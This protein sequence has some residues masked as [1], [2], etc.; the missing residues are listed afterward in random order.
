VSENLDELVGKNWDYV[1]AGGGSAGCVLA[2]RLSEDPTV[3]VLLLEAG[4]P[5]RSPFIRLPAGLLK[6]DKKYNW[7]YTAEPDPS[8]NGAVDEWG[9]GRVLGGSSSINGQMW[10]RGCQADFDGWDKLGAAGW[11][12]E[13]VLPYFRKAEAFAG[14]A[15]QWRGGK[16]PQTVSFGG[17]DHPLTDAFVT[18]A[19]QFGL[20]FNADYNGEHQNGVSYVQLSQRRGF[21]WSTA[22]GYLAPARRRKNLH[23]LTRT[24]VHRV[25]VDGDRVVAVEFLHGGMSRRVQVARE[26]ILSTGALAT[27]KVLLLSGIG[28]EDEITRHGIPMVA[29]LPGVGANLQEHPYTTMIYESRVPTLNSD[30]GV[31][32]GARAAWDFVTKGRGALTAAA[33]SAIAFGRF[34]GDQ[35]AIADFE[36]LFSAAGVAPTAEL[37]PE[38]EYHHDVNE[39]RPMSVP[40]MM[41]LPSVSHPVA[42]GLVSLHSTDPTQKPMVAHQLLGHPEDLAALRSVARVARDVFHSEALR[43]Y[44]GRELLPGDQV[45]TDQEW[46]TFLRAAAW[47]GEHPCGTCVI[48]TG[49]DAVVDPNLKVHGIEGLRVVDASVMP[50]VITG[51]TNAP[52]IMIAERAADLIRND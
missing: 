37:S 6:L 39:L 27:P 23:V 41:A 19:E 5:D 43:P 38:D 17:V 44:L 3:N 13:S 21:R 28:R 31:R 32:V 25:V 14:G 7:R 10:T 34:D 49:Q 8:R 52:T 12:W 2:N 29:N 42:R 16:G 18:A 46:E 45:Q 11:N 26:A 24:M 15:D 22:R 51:H 9:G 50:T 35:H 4:G 36:L 20:P 48:G 1:I 47:R 30:M 33:C 40:A